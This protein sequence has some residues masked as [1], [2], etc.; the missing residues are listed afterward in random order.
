MPDFEKL[1]DL[2]SERMGAAVIY[3]T[4]DFFAAKE[5]LL[6]PGRGEFIAGKYTENGKWMDGWESR[7]KRTPG[8][9][10]AIIRLA[11]PGVVRGL[12]VDTNH[13]LGNAPK[14]VSFEAL[15]VE[16]YVPTSQLVASTEWKPLVPET[17]VNP[18]S[19]NLIAVNGGSPI[20][21]LKFH[22]YPDGGVA[23]LRVYGEVVP[24]WTQLLSEHRVLDLAAVEHGG[25]PI[26]ASDEFFSDKRNLVLP[27]RSKD[28][29]DGWETKRRRGPGH[30]WVVV[31]LG[32]G[33]TVSRLVLET[34]HF[35]G[36]Y[37]DRCMVEGVH[38]PGLEGKPEAVS[39]AA[40]KPLLPETR[41]ESHTSH[42]FSDGQLASLGEITHV[43]LNIYPDGGVA[44]M[45][46]FGAPAEGK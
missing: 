45:R 27:G 37:P 7:R 25:L 38:A 10:W 1:V 30:D 18:G 13:F 28:M 21:H 4:D 29:G 35:K 40:W 42:V 22:I 36:N 12:D 46:V 41:M 16:G 11:M 5:N 44:R 6:H 15:S 24:N 2:A 17:S 43:R 39:A 23:R 31:K 20:T 8:H 9:D 34:T 26:L 14:A 33:G 19:Q 3:A 32:R